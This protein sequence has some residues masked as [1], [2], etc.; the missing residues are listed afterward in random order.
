MAGNKTEN[1][2]CLL[3]LNFLK[4]LPSFLPRDVLPKRG[5]CRGT[6]VRLQADIVMKR[7][8]MSDFFSIG[9]PRSS[10]YRVM[11]CKRGLCCQAVSVRHV[12]GSRQNE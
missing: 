11:R 8:N 3:V 12:R 6:S 2:S 9:Y 1:S 5:L 4:R 10:F 7:L